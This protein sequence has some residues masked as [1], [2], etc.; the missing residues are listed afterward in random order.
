MPTKRTPK[1]LQ[2]L[3]QASRELSVK[4]VTGMNDLMLVLAQIDPAELRELA[5]TCP[6]PLAKKLVTLADVL[7]QYRVADT[8]YNQATPAP[9]WLDTLRGSPGREAAE[10]AYLR[11]RAKP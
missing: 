8:H 11:E 10:R 9:R 2:R 3:T 1:E 7:E 6:P 4:L 5:Q